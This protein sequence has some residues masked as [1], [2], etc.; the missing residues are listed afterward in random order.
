[1]R[2][3]N[4]AFIDSNNLHLAVK[5][6]GWNLD[7]GKFRKY[8]TEKYHVNKAYIF[9]GYV[10]KHQDLY[11]SLQGRGYILI[12]KPT[13]VYKDGSTKGN[14]D[15]ELVLQAMID[16]DNYD[17]SVMVTG[18]GDFYCLVDYMIKQK[19]LAKLMVPN[20]KKYSALLKSVPSEYLAFVSDLKSKVGLKKKRTS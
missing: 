14:C 9:I 8:L 2:K 15:A 3:N 4:F 12:F 18:D 19:K 5:D 16:F 10:K 7:Y 17:Q 13:L 11:K 6:L 1:M 20:Q